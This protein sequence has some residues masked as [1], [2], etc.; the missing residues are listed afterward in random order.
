M[1][2]YTVNTDIK[3][4]WNTL[5]LHDSLP[6]S[7]AAEEHG[8]TVGECLEIVLLIA[9]RVVPVLEHAPA[10]LGQCGLA[11]LPTRRARLHLSPPCMSGPLRPYPVAETGPL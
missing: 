2:E 8:P 5:S 6:S 1:F 4:Y 10:D 11:P 7:S 9:V 3:P